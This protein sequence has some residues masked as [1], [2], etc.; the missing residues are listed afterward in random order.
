MDGLGGDVGSADSD[1]FEEHRPYLGAVAYRLLGSFSDAEDAVQDTWLRW[2]GVDRSQVQDVR[3]YLTK[4]VTRVCYDALGSARARRE[5][6]VGEWLPEPQVLG[7]HTPESVAVAG[8]SVSLALLAVLEQLSPAQRV[9]FVLH[10][11]FAV[12]FEE[13]GA[14]LERSPES[15]RQLAA[16]ARRDVRRRSPHR[17]VDAQAHLKAVAAFAAAAAGADM[18]ALV[19]VLA[20]DVVWHSDGGGVVSAGLRPIVGAVRVGRLA[21]ALAAKWLAPETG[22]LTRVAVV[23]GEMGLVN[24]LPSGEPFGVTAFTVVDGRITE[25]YVVVNPEKFSGVARITVTS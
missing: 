13:I 23:N 14:A 24:Y 12:G 1:G 16:R 19:D 22:V 10:D 25:I 21:L 6:Y 17:E 2:R 15:V 11:V 20:P 3:A 5:S 9:A 8:E 4:V 7:E 18:A